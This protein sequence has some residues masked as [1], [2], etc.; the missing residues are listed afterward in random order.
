MFRL[1]RRLLIPLVVLGA[2]FFGANVYVQHV[3]EDRV[4]SAVRDE[5][6]LS[7]KP[8]VDITGF[9]I[10]FK[11]FSGT[12]PRVSFRA[13]HA[14]FQGLAVSDIVVDLHDLVA[15]GGLLGGGK[16]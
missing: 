1:F 14:T 4:A 9:P 15:E 2:L 8:S 3:A 7:A 10:I 12:L 16:L 13:A 11:I 5:F 6:H